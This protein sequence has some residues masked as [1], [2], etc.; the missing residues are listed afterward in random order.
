V[1]TSRI[2][3]SEL[4]HSLTFLGAELDTYVFNP[5]AKLYVKSAEPIDEALPVLTI[6]GALFQSNAVGS[7][8]KGE[9]AGDD[10][11]NIKE[12]VLCAAAGHAQ[13]PKLIPEEDRRDVYTESTPLKNDYQE[14]LKKAQ[15]KNLINQSL[16]TAPDTRDGNYSYNTNTTGQLLVYHVEIADLDLVQEIIKKTQKNKVL[17]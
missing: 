1:K 4:D 6:S 3:V 5:V 7:E 14:F 11:E 9:K 15:N 12:I 16:I 8:I 2:G 10:R 17:S 13:L